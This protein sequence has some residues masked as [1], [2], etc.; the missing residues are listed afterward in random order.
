MQS[1]RRI[2]SGSMKLATPLA[3]ILAL[4]LTACASKP[5]TGPLEG[6]PAA[7]GASEESGRPGAASEDAPSLS[8]LQAAFAAQ[9]GDR[10]FFDLDSYQLSAEAL[11][12]LSRQADWLLRHPD[13]TVLI[14]GN[15][16]ERGTREY[17]VALGAR[18]A[19]A[20]KDFL[21]QRGVASSRMRTISYGK[22]RPLDPGDGEEAWS[23]NR[24][25]HTVLI[26]ATVR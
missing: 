4:G 22:E 2:R 8:A 6:P 25:A 26:D 5:K 15:C 20:A 17:N 7:P 14:E 10:V 12:A 1:R 18:R 23:R 9:A 24:N 19:S 3:L 13:V 21:T 16:D 11:A